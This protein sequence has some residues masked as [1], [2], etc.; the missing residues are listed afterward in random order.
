MVWN[1]IIWGN[2][3]IE[4]NIDL[5]WTGPLR[6]TVLASTPKCWTELAGQSH[7]NGTQSKV[8]SLSFPQSDRAR[9]TLVE[10]VKWHGQRGVSTVMI[11]PGSVFRR[12]TS[13]VT[14][15]SSLFDWHLRRPMDGRLAL[16][17]ILSSGVDWLPRGIELIFQGFLLRGPTH[18]GK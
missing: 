17:Q 12:I 4:I 14:S 5:D 11:V 13:R 7:S 10:F 6:T 1:S 3:S 8:A 9:S 15:L 2:W 18:K 16:L